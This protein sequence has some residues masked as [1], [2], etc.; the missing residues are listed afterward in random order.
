MSSPLNPN[1]NNSNSIKILLKESRKLSRFRVRSLL[2]KS[3][4]TFNSLISKDPSKAFRAIGKVKI[5]KPKILNLSLL[6]TK[7]I[8]V[9]A[10]RMAFM[11]ALVP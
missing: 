3:N 7:Y 11:I 8:K 6:V 4:L 9:I 2:K 10:L 1:P 5:V